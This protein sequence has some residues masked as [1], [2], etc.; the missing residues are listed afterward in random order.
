MLVSP[1]L[2]AA[3]FTNLYRD[4]ELINNSRASALHLDVMDGV[5]VRSEE[6]TSELQSQR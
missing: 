3:D 1:S 2:L 6:H 5:F 4:I